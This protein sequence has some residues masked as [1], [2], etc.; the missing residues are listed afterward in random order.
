M[1]TMI[2]TENNDVLIGAS[3]NDQINALEGADSILGGS[4]NDV[5]DAD[6]PK[7]LYV[8]LSPYNP[9]GGLFGISVNSVGTARPKIDTMMGGAGDDIYIAHHGGV[10]DIITENASEGI[11]T[12]KSFASY[13]LGNN[14]ENLTLLDDQVSQVTL[15]SDGT[16][17]NVLGMYIVWNDPIYGEL[18]YK[19]D[20]VNGTGN[21][22]NNQL[23]GNTKNNTLMGM[24][25]D[26]TLDG[27]A[28]NDILNGGEGNDLLNGGLGADTLMGGLGNDTYIVDNV[29]DVVVEAGAAYGSIVRVSTDSNGVQSNADSFPPV[30][31]ADGTQV[32]FMSVASNLVVGDTNA[33]SDIFVKNLG[34]GALTRVS[35]NSNGVQ[36]NGE[37]QASVAFS[38]DGT[39]VAFW[40]NSSNLVAGDT[41]GTYDV[42]VKNLNTG[43]V[44]R[45]STDS[46][47]V[48]GNGLS[49]SPVFSADGTQV[50][51]VSHADNLVAGDT[52]GVDDIFVK[53]LNTGVL[54]RV[55]TNSNG[56]QG[57]GADS[58]YPVF[59]ADGTQIAFFSGANNLVEGDT[60]GVADI[61]VKNLSTGAVIRVSTDSNG[62]QGNSFSY[63]HPVFSAD[64]TQVAFASY[65]SNLVAGDTNGSYDIFVK[66]LSTG[67]VTRVSTDASGNQGNKHSLD[68]VFSA[69]G[70][71]IA[72]YSDAT[73]LVAGDTNANRDIFVKNLSTGAVT[74]VSTDGDGVQGNSSSQSPV[75]SA[76]GTRIVFESYASNLVAGDTNGTYDIFVKNLYGTSAGVDTIQASISYTLGLNIENLTLTGTTQ[77]NGTGN[78]LNNVITGNSGNNVLEGGLGVDTLTGGDGNDT[79]IVDSTTD[80]ISDS[81][82]MDIVQSSVTYSLAS[83]ADIENL[84]LIG[85]AVGGTGN[86]LNNVIVGNSS[87]NVLEGG[88]GT[89]TLTGG[90]GNDT[91]IVDSTTD[92]ISDSIG[93]DI[94]QSSVTYSLA[95]H[96]E[97]E[98]LTL[99]GSV[100]LDG[101]GNSL[102][103][104]I[105][106]NSGNNVLEGG[107]GIDTLT[108]GN[109]NDTY[110]VDSTTDKIFD[111][112]GM[113]VV[114]SSVT[115]SLASHSDLENLTLTGSVSIN[116]TGNSLD[117]IIIGNSSNNILNGGLGADTLSG[118][119]GNDTYYVDNV[120]DVVT[121]NLGEG[122]DTVNATIDYSLLA[123][124]ENLGLQGTANLNGTG[125]E[126]NNSLT[127]NSGNNVLSGGLGNDVL[128][129]GL[130]ADTLSGGLGNDTYYVDN[131]GDVVT[132]NLGEG[133]DTVNAT[134]DYSLLANVENLGLQGTANLNGTGNE[135]N[136]CLT[137]NS[138]NNVLNGGLG[139]DVLN[140]GLGVDTLM[141]G[142]GNDIYYV[143]QVGDVVTENLG[144]GTDIV[145]ATIDY[146]LTSNVESLLLRGVANVNGTGNELNNSLMANS[147]NNTLSG[148]LGNDTLNGGLGNDTYSFGRGD[149]QDTV[150]DTSGTADVLSFL[151]GVSQ[152]QL[153]FKH[154][155]NNL[156]V[157]IIGTTDKVTVNNWYVG[158]TVN[159]IE[160]VHTANGNV[161][162]SSQ[163]AVLVNAM[164][165][166]TPP[167][168]GTTTL[169][170]VTYQPVLSAITTSWSS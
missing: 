28:G 78:S 110:I 79:Y 4:G 100:D 13:T 83:Y 82:G 161:L 88:L 8:D 81:M 46:S 95:S 51:F 60:N 92:I 103:N 166:L 38:T 165:S 37:C 11:D 36:G 30:I 7:T 69:D 77:I 155:G 122:T 17:I 132:E 45:V 52:N 160:E 35:T 3:G 71:Q 48:Q 151:S 144:E 56:E 142:L 130:G 44:T 55:S 102:N 59:S 73:N 1:T 148:G 135:L 96:T 133:T 107:L 61:F 143:D 111:S 64:G 39:Q 153:W 90:G 152:E 116:G 167:P 101:T 137:G 63:Y 113:D 145:Y 169:D 47:G 65:A 12:V 6:T 163:V 141:G 157:S 121:E 26:D 76:D 25:G 66:N 58:L 112:I 114:Q 91:Y 164:S 20:A 147:G 125:N 24:A 34:T 126:L 32:A 98:N 42:F 18:L 117:N 140:G 156:E 29:G 138:G 2:G 74:R 62:V 136:N 72:F 27:G 93:I 118:G 134:I 104:V 146:S 10:I 94:V 53:N 128:N 89:D 41:N 75:F 14:V 5:I 119:L 106:G 97:L 84:T 123:N 120:G 50:A 108:G 15:L 33:K 168:V 86:S 127:G 129:G 31:S 170:S 159:Q 49:H 149:G 115:Y 19:S 162:L 80:M 21:E 99:T 158:G 109:G 54:T 43:A 124:V 105:T 150:V 139:N 9:L 85:T 16:P 70:T 40:S 154:S 23:I 87:N 57:N 131:I 67:V 22:L 68:P